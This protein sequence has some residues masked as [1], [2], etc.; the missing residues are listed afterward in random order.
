MI[1]VSSSNYPR[2]KTKTNTYLKK[3]YIIFAGIILFSLF[4][5]AINIE[6]PDSYVFDEVYYGFTAEEYASG[7]I[8]AWSWEFTAPKG[9]SYTWDHPP[10]GKLIMAVPIRL[11]GKS[12]L[13]RRLMPLVAGVLISLMI[14]QLGLLLFPEKPNIA[15]LAT[16]LFSLD[17]LG[18]TLSRIGLV[19]TLLTLFI[20]CSI[21]FALKKN[22]IWSAIFLGM[23]CSTKWTG[24]YLVGFLGLFIP[25]TYIWTKEKISKNIQS[26]VGL[27]LMYLLIGTLVYLICYIPFFY[28]YGL[29]KWWALQHQMF[30]YHTRLTTTHSSQSKAWTW[31]F[32][33][34]PVWFYVKYEAQKT[35]N[36]YAMG[37]P[38][39]F[40]GGIIAVLY[41]LWI[42]VF[43][44][45]KMFADP[46]FSDNPEAIRTRKI[47]LIYLLIAYCMFW[48]PWVFSPRIMFLY[49]YLPSVPFLCL[50]LAFA[51]NQAAESTIKLRWLPITFLILSFAV[52]CFFYPYWTGIAVPKQYIYLF[53]W[54]STWG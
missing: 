42:I 29:S 15:L 35:R 23:A 30:W 49:H 31:P 48:V 17:G 9:F 53:H 13:A 39:I 20:V 43:S 46:L 16:A 44:K 8:D 1:D 10:L 54:L 27:G 41:T 45:L 51:I 47:S 5:K 40:W 7:N 22:Y 32:D 6:H 4:S 50:I 38:I 12:S 37:N 26:M 36:I 21:F 28:H 2:D 14:F 52:F 24:I 3:I 19:D 25:S 34:R 11:L 33:Y 18:L